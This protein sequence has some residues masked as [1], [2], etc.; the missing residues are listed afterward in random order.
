MKLQHIKEINQQIKDDKHILKLLTYSSTDERQEIKNRI[1]TL[2]EL[3]TI[4]KYS[5]IKNKKSEIDFNAP[6]GV[7]YYRLLDHNK[8]FSMGKLAIQNWNGESETGITGDWLRR[9][10]VRYQ[11]IAVES[12]KG[13]VV[14]WRAFK[15]RFFEGAPV[16][17]EKIA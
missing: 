1:E 6:A 5:E 8:V 13:A 11:A 17:R 14:H 4:K 16:R 2:K 15:Q 3:K 7:Y 12:T 9:S 10:E